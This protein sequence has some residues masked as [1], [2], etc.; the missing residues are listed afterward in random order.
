MN[1]QSGFKLLLATAVAACC[2]LPANAQLVVTEVTGDVQSFHGGWNNSSDIGKP[3]TFDFVYDSSAET[4]TL[5]STFYTLSVPITSAGIVGGVFGSGINLEPDGPGKGKIVDTI[6]LNTD[7]VTLDAFT[8]VKAPTPGFTGDVYGFSLDANGTGTT[9][10]LIRDVYSHG[11][12]D[13]KDSGT[14][15]LSNISVAEVQAPEIDPTSAISALT[16]LIGGLAVI[17]G[18]KL[19]VLRSA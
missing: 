12:L 2:A 10:D 18:R 9:V 19:V 6:N 17:R 3:V 8:S 4:T 1:L 5:T 11:Q 13:R 15:D 14:V 7:A 16:L